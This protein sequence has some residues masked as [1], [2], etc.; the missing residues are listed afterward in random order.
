MNRLFLLIAGP[1]IALT[2]AG[3]ASAQ[4]AINPG[5]WE[6]ISKVTSP[7]PTQKTEKRCIKPADVAKFMEGKINHIYTCTYP[8]KEVGGGKIRL[9][10]SCATK[11]GPPVPI[12]GQGVF[13]SDTMHIDAKVSLSV[14]G[15]SVPVK[16]STDARR[17]GDT[18]PEPAAG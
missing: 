9:Q 18:C 17:L 1:L 13:T 8:T 4:K 12:S 5:Y 11:D 2:A 15:L 6:T 16:A 3:A 10:G 7:F 14:G